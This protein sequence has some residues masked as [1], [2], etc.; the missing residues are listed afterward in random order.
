MARRVSGWLGGCVRMAR[1]VC[2]DSEEG[3]LGWQGGCVR[4]VGRVCM[5]SLLDT[6]CIFCT[7][8]FFQ[9]CIYILRKIWSQMPKW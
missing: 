6:A 9:S 3:V 2:Q 4:M 1:R 7:C 5:K 8:Q